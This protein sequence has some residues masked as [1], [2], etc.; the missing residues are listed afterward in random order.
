[1]TTAGEAAALFG[2]D[3]SAADPFSLGPLDAE[4]DQA[5]GQDPFAG[6]ELHSA[7]D[8]FGTDTAE[9]S[10]FASQP[11]EPLQSSYEYAGTDNAWSA[12]NPQY[13]ANHVEPATH[14]GTQDYVQPQQPA[15]HG[16]TAQQGQWAGYEPQHY[17]PPGTSF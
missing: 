10:A 14:I 1:M 6:Q 16:Y 17:N 13:A 9:D 11:E 15:A 7:T 4:A 8:L 2:T 3:D 12:Q 5:V